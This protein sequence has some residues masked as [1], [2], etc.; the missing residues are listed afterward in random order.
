[1]GGAAAGVQPLGLP[2]EGHAG[3]AGGRKGVPLVTEAGRQ[4]DLPFYRTPGS[5]LFRSRLYREP[6]VEYDLLDPL[7]GDDCVDRGERHPAISRPSGP[8]LSPMVCDLGRSLLR[9]DLGS[10]PVNQEEEMGR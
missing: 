1:M 6:S 2:R 9:S 3:R 10:P 8:L 5:C 4:P 7:G